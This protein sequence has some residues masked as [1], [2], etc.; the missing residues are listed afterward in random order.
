[1]NSLWLIALLFP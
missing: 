1:M